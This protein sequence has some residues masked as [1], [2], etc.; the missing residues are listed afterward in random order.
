MIAERIMGLIES[1]GI[2]LPRGGYLITRGRGRVI[3]EAA[4]S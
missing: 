4:K 2:R 1:K 3:V